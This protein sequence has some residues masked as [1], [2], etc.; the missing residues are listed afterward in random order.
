MNRAVFAAFIAGLLLAAVPRAAQAAEIVCDFPITMQLALNQLILRFEQS[1]GNTVKVEYAPIGVLA[2][3]LQ[4]GEAADVTILSTSQIHDLEASGRVV[5]G[6]TGEFARVGLGGFIAKGSPKIDLSSA[7]AVKR[8]LLAARSIA[9]SDPKTGVPS[10]KLMLAVIQ[11]L[12]IADQM[13]PKTVLTKNG[14]PLIDAVVDG[15]AAIG[16]TNLNDFL[17]HP[18]VDFAGPL[19]PGIQAYT[20]WSI[21]IVAAGTNHAAA[22]ALAAFLRSPESSAVMRSAGFEP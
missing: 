20:A 9:V 22:A 19:P 18:E 13:T 4:K 3:R 7:E 5:A 8:T 11:E 21:G 10:G 2:D 6:S 15:T 12:G 17:I 1:S 14:Q 16:F